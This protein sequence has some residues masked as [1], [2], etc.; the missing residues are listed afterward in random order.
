MRVLICGGRDFNDYLF[1]VYSLDEYQRRTDRTISEIIHGAAKGADACAHNYAMLKGI[2]VRAFPA[3]WSKYGR[4]AGP[5]RNKQML[6][7]GKPDI[8]I[9]FPGSVGTANM[10]KQAQERRVPVLKMEKA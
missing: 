5:I 4:G 10:I 2:P 8:V 3:D 6:D 9:A 1:F 7:E